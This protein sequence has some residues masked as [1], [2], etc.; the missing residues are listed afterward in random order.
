MQDSINVNENNNNQP[1]KVE[2]KIQTRLEIIS[3]DSPKKVEDRYNRF[4]NFVL[5]YGGEIKGCKFT[6]TS[7]TVDGSPWE[8]FHVAIFY[9]LPSNVTEKLLVGAYE[10]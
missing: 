2:R 10:N 9:N 4:A 3:S 6:T 1:V 7:G 8:T 5:G